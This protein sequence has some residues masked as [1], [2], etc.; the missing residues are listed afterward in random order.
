[1]PPEKGIARRGNLLEGAPGSLVGN[2]AVYPCEVRAILPHRT[3]LR[4]LKLG[5]VPRTTPGR[6]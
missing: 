5:F 1:V 2:N 4:H 6:T 3:D